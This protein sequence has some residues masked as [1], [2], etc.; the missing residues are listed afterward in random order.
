VDLTPCES[1]V[2][3]VL[4]VT[5]GFG[6]DSAVG[7]AAAAISALTVLFCVV[8]PL[9]ALW[10]FW[11]RQQEKRFWEEFLGEFDEALRTGDVALARDYLDELKRITYQDIADIERGKKGGKWTGKQLENPAVR[12]LRDRLAKYRRNVKALEQREQ[13]RRREKKSTP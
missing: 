10:R 4:A 9:C 6:L 2:A 11:K 5:F 3:A 13:Q 12:A 1:R 8:Y 7:Q